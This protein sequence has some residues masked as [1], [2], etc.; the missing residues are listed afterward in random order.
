ML[1]IALK[2]DMQALCI[3]SPWVVDR[4]GVDEDAA[5]SADM[6]ALDSLVDLQGPAIYQ[7]H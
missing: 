7:S 2:T 3:R 4:Y 6:L 5:F 1:L